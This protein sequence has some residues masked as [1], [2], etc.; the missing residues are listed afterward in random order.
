MATR[1]THIR[2]LPIFRLGFD[3]WLDVLDALEGEA[4]ERQREH[5]QDVLQQ[6]APYP[7]LEAVEW[8]DAR[9]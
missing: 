4:G 1:I 5:A 3:D 8:R 9:R 2:Q 6:H 7:W